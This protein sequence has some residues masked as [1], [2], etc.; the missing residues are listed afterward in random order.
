MRQIQKSVEPL[1]LTE[2]RAANQ[3]DLNFGYDLIDSDLRETIKRSLLDEQG[4]ICA[5]TGIRVCK[6]SSH[7]E[8]PKAQAH[9]TRGEDVSYTNMLACFP[10][11]NSVEVPYGARRKGAWPDPAQEYLFVSPLSAGCEPRFA[12][13]LRGKIT[14]RNPTDTAAAKTICA[15]GLDD[16]LLTILRKTAIDKTLEVRG[17]GPASL[18]V[19]KARNRLAGLERSERVGG[20]LEPFCFALKQA[21]VKHIFRIEAIRQSRRAVG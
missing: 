10:A 12:F 4:E 7:I 14:P 2:W 11:P 20:Q 18:S 16:K 6:D 9:C 1:S 19:S 17:A 5:Y 15:L 8:H 13:D 3:N 21:L